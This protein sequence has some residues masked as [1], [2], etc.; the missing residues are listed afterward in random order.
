[1]RAV[2]FC[3]PV[4]PVSVVPVCPAAVFSDEDVVQPETR[5]MQK[6]P[7]MR[8]SVAGFVRM[9]SDLP[10]VRNRFFPAGF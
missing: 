8:R 2:T 7:A 10:W 1:M 3:V 6:S 4:V 5:S 9:V